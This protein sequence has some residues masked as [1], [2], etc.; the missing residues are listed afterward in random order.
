MK[1]RSALNI[2][3]TENS[4]KFGTVSAEGNRNNKTTK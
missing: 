1:G 3:E 2:R 4:K